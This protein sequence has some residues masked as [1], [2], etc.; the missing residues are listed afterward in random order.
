MIDKIENSLLKLR[1]Q[2][3]LILCLTNIVTAEFVANCLLGIGAAP[4]MS[5]FEDEIEEL[6]K[7]ASVLYI[8]I[9][10][11]DSKFVSLTKKS[12]KI[13]KENNK[14]I[15]FDPVGSGATRL[16]TKLAKLVIH[17]ADITRGNSSEIISLCD[18]QY[19]TFGVESSNTTDEAVESAR[20]LSLDNN[21]VFIVSG[22]VDYITNGFEIAK[23]PFGSPLMQT[24]TG[25]GCSLS[26]V[27]AALH[28]VLKDPFEAS[29]VAMNYFALCGEIAAKKHESIGAF[30][31]ELLNQL[32]KPDF[33][34]MRE[35]YDSRR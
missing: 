28:A 15:I 25:M 29:V 30:K 9:G 17:F 19:T 8:N 32:H 16:R 18:N 11:L 35:L 4:M 6:I 34:L 21:A 1:N 33:E 23:V 12:I 26:A 27:I 22:K 31:S 13:A 10:T 7:M 14:P 3:P 2:K 20:R 24:V 5:Q